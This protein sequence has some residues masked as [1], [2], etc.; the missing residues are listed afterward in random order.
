MGAGGDA[1]A[2]MSSD[3]LTLA[4]SDD[5]GIAVWDLRPARLLAAACEVA[6]RDITPAEWTANVIGL[7]TY[8]RLCPPPT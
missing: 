2:V 3:G 4:Y 6:S 8:Q 1:F 5:H 7:G